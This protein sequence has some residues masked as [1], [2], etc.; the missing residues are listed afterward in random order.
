M[1]AKPSWTEPKR[2]TFVLLDF[3]NQEEANEESKSVE[4]DGVRLD[5]LLSIR[6]MQERLYQESFRMASINH[7]HFQRAKASLQDGMNTLWN[8]IFVKTTEN[9]W[10]RTPRSPIS[11]ANWSEAPEDALF[12]YVDIRLDLSKPIIR[13]KQT[14]GITMLQMFR[15][16][17]MCNVSFL[18]E[19]QVVRAH[20][21]VLAKHAPFL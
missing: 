9:S 7:R 16:E 13:S 4:I 14:L 20:S 12:C 15:Q 2:K 1:S 19:G 5:L 6:R 18:V 21:L 17:E 8:K 10:S 3:E 11:P